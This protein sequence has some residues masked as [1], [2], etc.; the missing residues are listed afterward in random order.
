M[1]MLEKPAGIRNYTKKKN[2]IE[3]CLP[4]GTKFQPRI[5]SLRT[6][7]LVVLKFTCSLANAML[8]FDSNGTKMKFL[9]ELTY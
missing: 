3:I 9:K 7:L 1:S 2:I 6:L 8:L 4:S 5:V